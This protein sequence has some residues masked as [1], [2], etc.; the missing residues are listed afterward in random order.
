MLQHGHLEQQEKHYDVKDFGIW[1]FIQSLA[2]LERVFAVHGSEENC[3]NLVKRIK[4]KLK[5]KAHAPDNLDAY[6][7]F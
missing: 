5:I 2:G 7:L 1:N 4:D 6:R 3:I